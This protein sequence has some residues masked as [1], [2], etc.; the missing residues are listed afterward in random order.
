MSKHK[1]NTG[2]YLYRRE[3]VEELLKMM[4]AQGV[5]EKAPSPWSSQ[6]VLVEKG[7]SHEILCG[8]CPPRIE[9]TLDDLT[10]CSWFLANYHGRERPGKT[11][12]FIGTG[13]WQL[14]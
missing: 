11:A 4:E 1:I 13:L 9:D 7:L 2:D 10:G 14:K 8:L 12:F 3:E 5:I 6:I